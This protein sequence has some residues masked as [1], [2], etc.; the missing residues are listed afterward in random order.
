MRI[1][2]IRAPAVGDA[3]RRTFHVREP[4]GY[5]ENAR[6]ISAALEELGH[7]AVVLRD[8]SALAA[9]L[10]ALKPDVAWVCSAGG[11]GRDPMAH[12]PA[13]L[14]LCGVPY[15]GS[16]PLAAAIADHKP[17]AKRL[18]SAVGV[19]TPAGGTAAGPPWIVK[20]ANGLAS[21]GVHLA[22]DEDQ[23]RIAS[24]AVCARYGGDVLVERFI[25]GVD[26]TLPMIETATG[27][28]FLPALRRSMSWRSQPVTDH[29]IEHPRSD[30]V[31]GPAVRQVEDAGVD[32]DALRDHCIEVFGALGLRQLARMD[33]RV[34]SGGAFLLE[35]NHKPDL[36]RCGLVAMS[37]ALAG[38]GHTELIG[39]LLDA[40]ALREVGA[41][42]SVEGEV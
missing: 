27:I 39:R 42:A 34:G 41:A 21:C 18:F 11:Q 14:E 7:E 3:V 13:V 30:L 33:F 10:H 37:A 12:L 5:E 29:A 38:I 22:A 20:P 17:T 31:E 16:P 1:A 8:G 26:V 25:D 19:P 36:R 15:V 9:T 4:E 6:D 28:E 23:L 40:A 35:A 24:D 32:L 2:V